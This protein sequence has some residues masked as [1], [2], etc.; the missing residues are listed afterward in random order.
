MTISQTLAK[1]AIELK[2]EDI[3][4]AIRHRAK[5]GGVDV[6][7]CRPGLAL[8]VA[9]GPAGQLAARRGRAAHDGAHVTEGEPEDVVQDEGYMFGWREP[10]QHDEQRYPNAVVQGDPLGGIEVGGRADLPRAL[11]RAARPS[12]R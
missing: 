10:F 5:R 2:Y 4:E 1:F 3:P 8:D 12:R 6:E 9:P 11:F 7:P